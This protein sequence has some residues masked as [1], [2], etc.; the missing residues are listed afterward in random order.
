MKKIGF[1]DH[2]LHEWHAVNY[3]EMIKRLSNG[4]MEVCYAY[5]EIDNP[6]PEAPSNAEWAKNTG[7][8]LLSTAEEVV[9]KS[10]Y[11]IVLSPD[12]PERHEDL[13]KI[14]FKA[15]KRV[16]VD[17]TFA[18]DKETAKRIFAEAEKYNTP[19]Y[20]CS[21]LNFATEY[22]DIDRSKIQNVGTWGQGTFA[23]Y[24][25]HQIEPIVSLMGP[26]AKRVM[27][28]GTETFPKLYIEYADGRH[29]ILANYPRATPFMTNVGYNDGTTDHLEI[30]SNY[31]ENFIVAMINFFNTG[32]IPVSHEQT[33]DVIAIREAGIKAMATPFEWVEI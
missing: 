18:D 4:E 28:M 26:G 6:H 33:L 10:D 29:A 8:E 20:S 3:P 19:T 15:G 32:E 24:A 12:N 13:C 31:F 14:A 27:F 1:I 30:K 16:Y 21:A 22:K 17:K 23:I 9:E 11:I 5:G 2:Y 25:I 7:V